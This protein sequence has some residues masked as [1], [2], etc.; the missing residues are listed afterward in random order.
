MLGR[1]LF[2]FTA[3]G[4]TAI[5]LAACTPQVEP[6]SMDYS[7]RFPIGVRAET[8][9]LTLP[10]ER[11][12]DDDRRL[13]SFA[14]GCLDRGHGPLTVVAPVEPRELRERLTASGVPVGS[15][16]TIVSDSGA[17]DT[18]TLRYE[19]YV[20]TLPS[21]GDWSGSAGRNPWNDVHSN[22]G[23]AQQNNLG[24][25]AADPADL[26]RMREPGPTDTANATRVIQRYRAGESPAAVQ[27]PLQNSGAAGTTSI[28]Q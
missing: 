9:A 3:I 4:A 2:H 12:G 17:R 16:R 6:P 7:Q 26:V 24:V 15:V 19:R 20:A 21:C 25:M 11:A 28:R 8:M 1:H 14:A 23:C 5:A 18:V 22:F 13:A 27:S 10:L